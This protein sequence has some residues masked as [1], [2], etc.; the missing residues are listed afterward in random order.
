MAKYLWFKSVYN[1]EEADLEVLVIYATLV[2]VNRYPSIYA[3]KSQ[4][5]FFEIL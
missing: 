4:W 5:T 2:L 1:P 3:A